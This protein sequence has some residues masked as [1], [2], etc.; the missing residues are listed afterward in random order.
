MWTPTFR[1]TTRYELVMRMT[2]P[3]RRL[4]R[5]GHA[6]LDFPFFY[7]LLS[8]VILLFLYPYTVSETGEVG[9]ALRLFAWIVPVFGV[10]AV[11][12][13]R[14]LM[15]LAL[16]F[17]IPSVV[18]ALQP[19]DGVFPQA[20]AMLSTL[21]FFGF[22]A[23]VVLTRVIRSRKVTAETIYGAISVYLLMGLTWMTAYGLLERLHPGSFNVAAAQNPDSILSSLDLLYFSFVTLTTLGYGDITPISDA[24]R[25]LAF[26]EAITGVMYLTILVARLVGMYAAGSGAAAGTESR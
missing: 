20:L 13:D 23:V 22:T 7:L 21:M 3:H 24:A 9:S 4:G 10:Y 19:E 2:R 8:M 11:S 12:D 17:G 14:R 6:L 26:M 5:A 16:L 25:S 18:G 15:G 1:P